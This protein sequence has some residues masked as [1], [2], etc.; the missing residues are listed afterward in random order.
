MA[1][2]L[3]KTI[4]ALSKGIKFITTMEKTIIGLGV[5]TEVGKKM[6]IG[7]GKISIRVSFMFYSGTT[8]LILEIQG[9]KLCL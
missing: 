6:V 9:W 5:E 7:S 1:K 4:E 2:D 8:I 3:I